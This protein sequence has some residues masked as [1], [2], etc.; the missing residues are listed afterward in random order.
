MLHVRKNPTHF[1]IWIIL[2]PYHV[3]LLF[4]KKKKKNKKRFVRNKSQDEV[5]VGLLCEPVNVLNVG[6]K[7]PPLT[8]QP[9]HKGVAWE[10]MIWHCSVRQE[11]MMDDLWGWK[12]CQTREQRGSSKE[13]LWKAHPRSLTWASAKYYRTYIQISR[14]YVWMISSHRHKQVACVFT[15]SNTLTVTCIRNL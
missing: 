1:Y 7:T 3:L 4:V 11:A 15:L 10:G 6:V 8:L 14:H 9:K 12:M 5:W 13:T 2:I